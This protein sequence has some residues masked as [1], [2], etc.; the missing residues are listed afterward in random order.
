MYGAPIFAKTFLWSLA[1]LQCWLH[2]NF[3]ML[4]DSSL[5]VVPYR[6]AWDFLHNLVNNFVDYCTNIQV[7][8]IFQG[9]S[10]LQKCTQLISSRSL[11]Y[12]MGDGRQKS[13]APQTK[14]CAAREAMFGTM[15]AWLRQNVQS[16]N[17]RALHCTALHCT[18]CANTC[19]SSSSTAAWK[20]VVSTG[21]R[22]TNLS[23]YTLSDR[24]SVV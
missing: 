8:A 5:T 20:V 19:S 17:D 22:S 18:A 14:Q 11:S 16:F 24:K 23:A 2:C 4:H 7:K 15:T 12:G 13:R 10:V 6:I 21:Y 3:Y 1:V 9:I